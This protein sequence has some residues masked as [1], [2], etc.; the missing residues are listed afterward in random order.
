MIDIDY[1]KKGLLVIGSPRSGSHMVSDI[2]YN[3]ST[4]PNKLS[5]GEIY[6]DR[7]DNVVNEIEKIKKLYNSNFIFAS[8]VQFWAKNL[9]AM[10]IGLLEDFQIVNLRRRDKVSQYIS[11]AV[12]RAQQQADI[13]R[14]SPSWEDYCEFLPW[15]STREDIE[16][17]VA[18]QNLDFAF[19]NKNILYY[20]D[21]IAKHLPT[22]F[23]KNQYPVPHDKIVTDYALVKDILEKYTYNGR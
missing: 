9:L 18:E 6:L 22:K 1:T 13:I 23:I 8:I 12:F 7:Q 14:H 3:L 2:F 5:L 21:V 17:F 10:D 15:E 4:A 11:W 16:M 20:E 19:A